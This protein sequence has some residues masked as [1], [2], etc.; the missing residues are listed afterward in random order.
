MSW[1]DIIK[2]KSDEDKTLCPKCKK[3]KKD[4]WDKLCLKCE[5]K[6][7]A[8]LAEQIRHDPYGGDDFASYNMGDDGW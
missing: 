2:N 6:E 1:K 4:P 3:N 8:K 5:L 7:E